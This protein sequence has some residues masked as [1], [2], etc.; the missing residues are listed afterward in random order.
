M[1]CLSVLKGHSSRVRSLDWS[2]DGSRL[3]SGSWDSTIK[4]WDMTL[5]SESKS[6]GHDDIIHT[7]TWASDGNKV[8]S[9]SDDNTVRL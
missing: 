9:E 8:L 5:Q 4:I 7:T 6:R 3:A 1:Q 2:P